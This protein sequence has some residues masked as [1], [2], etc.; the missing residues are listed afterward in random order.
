MAVVSLKQRPGGLA[1]FLTPF[2]C[3]SAF[4]TAQ[5][6]AGVAVWKAKPDA[7]GAVLGAAAAQQAQQAVKQL[8]LSDA[9]L[10][11]RVSSDSN[12][13]LAAVVA[14]AAGGD[15]DSAAGGDDG[16]RMSETAKATKKGRVVNPF[17]AA[18]AEADANAQNKKNKNKDGNAQPTVYTVGMVEIGND[19]SEHEGVLAVGMTVR[20]GDEQ[21]GAHSC[22]G[23]FISFFPS[24]LA[25]PIPAP[26]R[27]PPVARRILPPQNGKV[28][29]YDLRYR[30]LQTLSLPHETKGVT[31]I[32]LS[33]DTLLLAAAQQA[34]ARLRE[35]HP[36]VAP[37]PRCVPP[38]L[39]P[40]AAAD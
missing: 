26:S 8:T 28:E 15:D 25:D 37:V 38:P 5:G 11:D 40:Q 2:S 39:A 22:F 16:A 18:A 19:D 6:A 12:A 14:A 36:R 24:Y 30:Q 29:L 4:H 3:C 23:C 10:L 20:A 27:S 32:A 31:A 35:Q 21:G 34:R 13:N 33:V 7:T 1:C 9:L 17:I